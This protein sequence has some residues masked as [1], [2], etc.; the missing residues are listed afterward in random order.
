MGDRD[1]NRQGPDVRREAGQQDTHCQG[2]QQQWGQSSA[3]GMI[4]AYTPPR[5]PAPGGNSRYFGPPYL[6]G[7]KGQMFDGQSFREYAINNNAAALQL[8]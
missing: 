5:V 6:T 7:A 2:S 1:K 8:T 4:A 3:C